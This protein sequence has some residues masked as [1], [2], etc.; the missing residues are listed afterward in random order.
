MKFVNSTARAMQRAVRLS[1]NEICHLAR[2]TAILGAIRVALKTVR[3]E[4]LLQ[5]LET[6]GRSRSVFLTC[7]DATPE[8]LRWAVRV[9]SKHTLR[10]RPCLTE[11]LALKL[12]YDSYGY[13]CSLKIGVQKAGNELKAHAWLEKPDGTVVIGHL[14][15]ALDDYGVLFERAT[16]M[17]A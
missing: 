11:A 12:L 6:I 13:R 17:R 14:G 4:T 3:F 10:E 5:Q 1:P 16:E 7:G 8:Q 2:A 9:V 15:N